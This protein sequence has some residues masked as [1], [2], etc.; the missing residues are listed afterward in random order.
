MR[1]I[2]LSCFC[3]LFLASMAYAA[4]INYPLPKDAQPTMNRDSSYGP[5]NMHLQVYTTSV[6]KEKLMAF[7][8]QAL[9]KDGWQ[10][11]SEM[12]FKKG[13]QALVIAI[14]PA[15]AKFKDGKTMFSVV[16]SNIPSQEE[17]TAT[18]KDAPDKVSFMPVYPG[19]RQMFLFDNPH[20]ASASYT[21]DDSLKDVV[22]FYE[23]KML[24]YGWTLASA[25]PVSEK[26]FNSQ[27]SKIA[28]LGQAG[29][30]SGTTMSTELNFKRDREGCIIHIYE[31]KL[32]QAQPPAE[33]GAD[34][35]Q[36][37]DIISPIGK[38]QI[39]VTYNDFRKL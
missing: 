39:L 11:S 19:T 2:I 24:N 15:S 29:Q 38:T 27:E 14:S 5:V 6:S 33:K 16:Q 18:K 20:G 36:V 10:E 8:R 12:F 1:R 13:N 17:M 37:S 22:F 30:F 9:N 21:T 4:D 23:A 31:G 25:T 3:V 34:K 7:Y 28:N 26:K 35:T 32:D